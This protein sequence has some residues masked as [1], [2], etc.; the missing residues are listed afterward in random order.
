LPTPPTG[1]RGYYYDTKM[2]ALGISITSNGSLSFIVYRKANGKPERI[3]LGRFP[4]LSI[5]QARRKAEAIIVVKN[6][7]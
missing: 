6:F 4:D 5:E 2:R 3:T 1:K 7:F